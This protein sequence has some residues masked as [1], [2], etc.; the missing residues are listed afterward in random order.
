[1]MADDE[2]VAEGG[3]SAQ[4]RTGTPTRVEGEDFSGTNNQEAGVDEADF[5]KTDG[6]HIYYLQ[7]RNLH[8]FGVPEFG[9]LEEAYN[10]TLSGTPVAMMLDGDQLVVISTLNPWSI[11]PNHPVVDAMGWED[12]YGSWR[13]SSL[14]KFTVFD[15]T[16]RS[17]SLI[18]ISEPTRPY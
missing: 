4:T 3:N 13:T 15:I 14:T 8:I 16:N 18:H 17:L 1:M 10:T 5:L 7:G 9:A 2:A 11:S 12:S 6:Y